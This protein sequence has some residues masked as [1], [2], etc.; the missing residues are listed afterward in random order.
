[1]NFSG[2]DAAQ[3]AQL[4][5]LEKYIQQDDYLDSHRDEVDSR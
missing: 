2:D 5:G 4:A 1:M 3:S